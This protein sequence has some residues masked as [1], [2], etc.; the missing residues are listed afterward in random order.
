MKLA[1]Y[2]ATA[3]ILASVALLVSTG[4]A[5][6]CIKVWVPGVGWVCI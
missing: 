2:A 1:T 4:N 3:T 5:A 6:A